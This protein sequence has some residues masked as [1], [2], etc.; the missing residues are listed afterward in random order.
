MDSYCRTSAMTP[1]AHDNQSPRQVK[2]T[3]NHE[4]WKM[5][6]NHKRLIVYL[7]WLKTMFINCNELRRPNIFHLN[8][9]KQA[10]KETHR[11][12]DQFSFEE[13]H[14]ATRISQAWRRLK[15]NMNN[16]QCAEVKWLNR[17]Y[18]NPHVII[19]ITTICIASLVASCFLDALQDR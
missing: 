10:R 5:N 8:T 14:K 16:F 6:L 3:Q 15:G 12:I 2:M 19:V 4:R 7:K 9:S 13:Q 1:R 17:S 11:F 18:F